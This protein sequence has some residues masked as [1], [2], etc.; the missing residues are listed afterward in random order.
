ML[1]LSVC[2]YLQSRLFWTFC[3][4]IFFGKQTFFLFMNKLL[5]IKSWMNFISHFISLRICGH[6]VYENLNLKVIRSSIEFFYW[7]NYI[8]QMR[9]GQLRS[10]ETEWII[11]RNPLISCNNNLLA[12]ESN[13]ETDVLQWCN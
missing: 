3:V 9:L 5:K 13:K 6:G 8:Q 7:R 4:G 1:L 11:W 12:F 2:F 10:L